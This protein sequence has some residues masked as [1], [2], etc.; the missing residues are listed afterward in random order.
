MG[1]AFGLFIFGFVAA[2][3]GVSL[4]GLLNM[5]AVKISKNEDKKSAYSYVLGALTVIFIQTYIAIFCAKLIESN[6]FISNALQE[7]GFVIFLGLTIY[8]LIFA[9]KR[10]KKKEQSP[11]KN[12]KN[13][14]RFFY[15][16]FLAILNVFPVPYYVF[17]SI[18]IATYQFPVFENP[19]TS[20]F[21]LGVVLGS[22]LMFYLYITFFKKSSEDAFILRNINYCIGSITG[23]IALITLYKLLQ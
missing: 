2:V 7:I 17:L 4:P 8:F 10:E 6:P 13:Q 1:D 15:G 5:T 22:A 23:A 20:L 18:T 21:C 3:I 19:F 9:K 14:N 11:E 12:T 16:A